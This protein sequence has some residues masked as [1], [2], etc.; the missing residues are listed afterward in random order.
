MVYVYAVGIF[1][2]PS[3]FYKSFMPFYVRF[4][5]SL[6]NI[7]Q[8]KYFI[9]KVSSYSFVTFFTVWIIAFYLIIET[10]S[11]EDSIYLSNIFG[12]ISLLIPYFV[13]ETFTFILST[14]CSILN[15]LN[16]MALWF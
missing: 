13:F 11:F 14:L 16:K 5:P 6:Q 8:K 9:R 7:S 10:V 15:G 4:I 12:S 1:S 3:I 2:V